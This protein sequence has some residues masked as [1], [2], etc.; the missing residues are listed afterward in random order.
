VL[1]L[2]G[3]R[4][5]GGRAVPFGQAL[6]IA[7]EGSTFATKQQDKKTSKARTSVI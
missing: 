7:E 2:I 5:A 3:L 4:I 6:R 1:A